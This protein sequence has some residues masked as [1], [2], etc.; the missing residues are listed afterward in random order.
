LSDVV[1]TSVDQV[2]TGWLSDVL[3]QG[4]TLDQGAVESFALETGVA[5]LSTN[6]RLDLTYSADAQG[7]RPRKL[8]LKMVNTDLKDEFFDDTEINYYFRDYIGLESA[9]LVRAYDA[10]YSEAQ[11]RY[12]LLMADH[13][14]THTVALYKPVTLEYGLALAEA[15]AILHA[16]W[17]GRERLESGKSPIPSA[18]VIR[19]FV[20][21]AEPGAGHIIA[22]CADQLKPHWPA[23]L[24]EVYAHHPRLMI[25]RTRDSPDLGLVITDY[26]L[27]RG[28]TGKQVVSS[29]RQLRGPHFKAIVITGDTASAVH[30]FDGDEALCW[31][32]KPVDPEQLLTL[33]KRLLAR[34]PGTH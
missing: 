33:I 26:H 16:H 30:R 1:I 17:W 21:I 31:M 11:R 12:H 27:T 20:S 19:R 4:G 13:S 23:L 22:G 3:R 5:T 18:D 34:A 28:D 6:A 15:L 32:T 2:T 7:A 8:F 9:P 10:A 25:E 14:E 24:R 29:V